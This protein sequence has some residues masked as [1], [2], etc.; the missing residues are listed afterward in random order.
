M[1][2]HI[3]RIFLKGFSMQV[4]WIY[5]VYSLQSFIHFQVH[6]FTHYIVNAYSMP[7]AIGTVSVILTSLPVPD[8]TSVSTHLHRP[9]GIG[10]G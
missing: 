6:A 8:G 5:Y 4:I 7:G 1:D 9:Y 10:P 2:I 3:N